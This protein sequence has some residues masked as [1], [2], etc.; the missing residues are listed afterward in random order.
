MNTSCLKLSQQTVENACTNFTWIW[1]CGQIAWANEKCIFR[2]KA[3]I[4]DNA[5]HRICLHDKET[6]GQTLATK[7]LIKDVRSAAV[8]WRKACQ[9]QDDDGDDTCSA[10]KRPRI[11]RTSF[12][13]KL[14]FT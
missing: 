6:T 8:T 13:S 1:N 5:D 2:R 7:I 4:D 9:L 3:L 11:A 10:S 12:G 14:V